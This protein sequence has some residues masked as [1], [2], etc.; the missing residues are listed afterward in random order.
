MTN[1]HILDVRSEPP[2]RRHVLVFGPLV[3]RLR[4]GRVGIAAPSTGA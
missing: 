4:I 3:W 1:E 2:A